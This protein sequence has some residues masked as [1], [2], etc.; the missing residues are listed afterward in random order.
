[1]VEAVTYR[2]NHPYTS[3]SIKI[4]SFPLEFIETIWRLCDGIN[5]NPSHFH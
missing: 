1:M 2:H 5:K 3:L 4:K